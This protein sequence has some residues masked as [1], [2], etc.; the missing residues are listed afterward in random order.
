MDERAIEYNLL[1]SYCKNV[2]LNAK[3]KTEYRQLLQGYSMNDMERVLLAS[4]Q[5]TVET[6]N[7]Y[8]EYKCNEDEELYVILNVMI[9]DGGIREILLPSRRHARN[10]EERDFVLKLLADRMAGFFHCLIMED[11]LMN[12]TELKRLCYNMGQQ[13]SAYSQET[14]KLVYWDKFTLAMLEE[15]EDCEDIMRADLRAWQT[16]LNIVTE[17]MVAGF[18]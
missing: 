10:D 18:V 8:E 13:H 11:V 12:M 15:L 16:L 6:L 2:T 17:N 14:F 5:F 1:Q 7:K 3:K 4:Q 9:R